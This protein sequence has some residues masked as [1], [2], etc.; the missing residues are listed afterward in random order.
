VGPLAGFVGTPG[1]GF[2][3]EEV[4]TALVGSEAVSGGVAEELLKGGDGEEVPD[5]RGIIVG[6][7]DDAVAV[8]APRGGPDP[9]LM[10]L[11]D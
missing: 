2:G 7:G 10:A 1:F 11:E 8:G 9:A 4:G 3:F 5:A 6:S